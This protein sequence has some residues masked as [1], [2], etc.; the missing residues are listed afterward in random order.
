M[1]I[2]TGSPGGDFL[3]STRHMTIRNKSSTSSLNSCNRKSA[4]AKINI[5]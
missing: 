2:T 3:E 1:Q 5:K 4:D